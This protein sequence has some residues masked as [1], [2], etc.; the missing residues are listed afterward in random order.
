VRHCSSRIGVLFLLA[1]VSLYRVRHRSS[2]VAV[3]SLRL[4]G[5]AAAILSPRDFMFSSCFLPIT[6]IRSGP[7]GFPD[8]LGCFRREGCTHHHPAARSQKFCFC[9]EAIYAESL[10]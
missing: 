4:L 6:E 5:A 7:M 3:A 1:V 2:R 8:R 9:P 10:L